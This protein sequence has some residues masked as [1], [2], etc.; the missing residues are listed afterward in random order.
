MDAI[1][2]NMTHITINAVN[3]EAMRVFY[4]DLFGFVEVGQTEQ[5]V[6][7]AFQ[8]DEEPVITLVF[9]S[10]PK[11]KPQMGLYHYA[12]LFP[13]TAEL[14]SLIE[15]LATVGYPMGA[16]DHFVSEAFYLNDPDGNG[17]EL[18]HDRPAE[19]WSWDNGE[20]V[21]GTEEVDVPRLLNEKRRDWDGFP[22]GMTLGHLHF[23]GTNLSMSDRFFKELLG[24]EIV[25]KLTGSAHFYSHNRYH[26]HHAY[27]TWQ[28]DHLA[29]K[30]LGEAG[31]LAWDVRVDAAYFAYLTNKLQ[32]DYS[33]M[34]ILAM[35]DK[36]IQLFDAVGAVVT[37]TIAK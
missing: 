34:P 37:I 18:Y 21:M 28:G 4:K 13:N 22:A 32:G 35:D 3:E 17:I 12:V 2:Y 27:N 15:R 1:T 14:A 16:G 31:L 30:Q 11:S 20:I 36:H 33:D 7:Y 8:I 23:S 25:S 24:M 19:G 29:I 6:S 9:G 5:S 26:H 10:Q